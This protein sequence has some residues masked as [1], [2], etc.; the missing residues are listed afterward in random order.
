[1]ADHTQYWK[2]NCM[3]DEY[4]GLWH[5]W[6]TEQVVAVGWWPPKWGLR[7]PTEDSAWDLARRCLLKVKPEDRIVVQ[8][9]NWRIGRIGTVLKLKISDDQWNP[10]VPR[11]KGNVGEM[12]RRLEVHWDLTTGPLAPQFA[13]QLPPEGRPN[14]RIWRPTLSEVPKQAFERIEKAARD[15]N[16]WVS[17]VPGFAKE[18]AMSEFISVSPHLLEDGLRPYPSAAAR[19]QVFVDG[20]RLDVLL[21]DRDN[22]IVIVECKQGAPI[23]ADIQQLRGYMR[24]AEKLRT[25]LKVGRDIRGIL[26]HGGARK[27][28]ADVRHESLKSPKIELVTFT[29]NV[30]F[31]PSS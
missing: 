6:F 26:V 4:P 9:K 12:G 3:E 28:R 2:I 31:A 22:T 19:E 25:G 18:R 10:T 17:I 13:I 20:S 11:Q 14:M 23:L 8:L 7:T 29:V 1:M 16:H 24:N 30:G 21:L 5:T 15:E 27:L